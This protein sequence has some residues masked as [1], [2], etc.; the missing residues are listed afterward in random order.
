MRR[1]NA[2]VC[3]A[4]GQYFRY[5]P[6]ARR[7]GWEGRVRLRMRVEPDGRLSHLQVSES[8]GYPTLDAAALASARRIPALREA[9]GWLRG[10]PVDLVVA[11]EYRLVDG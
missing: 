8:S 11:V 3:L 10:N 9:A 7:R 5:P 1:S 2:R 6:L 4:L